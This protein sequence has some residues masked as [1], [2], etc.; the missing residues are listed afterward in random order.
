MAQTK[1]VA[2]VGSRNAKSVGSDMTSLELWAAPHDFLKKK[3]WPEKNGPMHINLGVS[4]L[5]EQ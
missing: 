4:L 5:F 1:I 3:K 2:R